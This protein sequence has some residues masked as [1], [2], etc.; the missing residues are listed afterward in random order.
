LYA[1]E[2]TGNVDDRIAARLMHL[3]EELNKLGTTVVIATHNESIVNEFGRPVLRID[4]GRLRIIPQEDS[5][6]KK[7]KPKLNIL[8]NSINQ[9]EAT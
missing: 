1:D 5:H 4:A 6:V 3:F 9:E 2:P 8:P 7:N